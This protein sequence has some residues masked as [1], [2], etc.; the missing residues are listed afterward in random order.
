[1]IHRLK[2]WLYLVH[3]WIGIAACLLFAMWFASGLVMIYV[4][5]PNLGRAERLAGLPPIDWLHVRVPPGEAL[6]R[7]G[8]AIPPRGMALEMR[9]DR[10]VWRIRPRLGDE[11]DIAAVDGRRLAGADAREA[12][13][14]AEIFSGRRA[15]ALSSVFN[16]QW[17]VAGTFDGHRPLWKVALAGDGGPVL[18]VSSHT[19]AVM[20]DTDAHERFWNWLGSV[21]HWLYPTILRQDNAAWRQVVM[22]V[23]GPCIVAALT[24][25]WIGILRTRIGL[26]RFKGGRIMPYRGWMH[27]HHVAGLIGGLFLLGWI[28]SGWLSVDPF[29]LFF[30]G[31]GI[32]PAARAQ[33]ER[34]GAPPAI[35]PDRLAAAAEGARRVDLRWLAGR[36][37]YV[38][39]GGGAAPPLIDAATLAPAAFTD[40]ELIRNAA[41]L[42]PG[43]R[44]AAA[45]RLTEAD[46]YWYETGGPPLLPVL[47]VRY[48]DPARTW[49][50][51]DPRTGA[52]LGSIDARG[53]LYRW[54]FDLLHK[55]D[56]NLLTAHRPAWDVLLWLLSIAGLVTSV[57]GVWIG[58]RR[59]VGKRSPLARA[60]S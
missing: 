33:Y 2:R 41:R 53:R 55:W 37:L 39:D 25:M 56:L 45:D 24:G 8:L 35:A 38:V 46:N 22:W 13:R 54:L 36:A 31:S 14:A 51:I 7:A 42:I 6:R 40:P 21:P 43:A 57:S 49:V 1:M 47:R 10:P 11:I 32:T 28:F 44:I 3:R 59:L 19:G 34:A 60:R 50:H 52:I 15:V 16:D 17:T 29:R 27:W 48:T 23:S 58:W 12:R 30:A 5:F 20:L 4:P 26:R 18:Y 9:G